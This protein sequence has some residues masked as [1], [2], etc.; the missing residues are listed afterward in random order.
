MKRPD[1]QTIKKRAKEIIEETSSYPEDAQERLM[2][3]KIAALRELIDNF[4]ANQALVE[5]HYPGYLR[6]D[7]EKLLGYLPTNTGKTSEWGL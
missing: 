4:E 1:E 5:K 6:E 2:L 7:V 3:I